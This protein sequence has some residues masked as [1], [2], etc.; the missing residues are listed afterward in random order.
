MSGIRID[1]DPFPKSKTVRKKQ[2]IEPSG[3]IRIG[4]HLTPELN[5]KIAMAAAETDRTKSAVVEGF[6]R[7]ALEMEPLA[8]EDL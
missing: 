2:K 6:L 8:E 4:F 7:A 5:R 1:K 3:K